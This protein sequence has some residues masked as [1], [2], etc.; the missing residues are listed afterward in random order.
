VLL[1]LT[2]AI[3]SADENAMHTDWMNVVKG[4]RDAASGTEVVSVEEDGA[5]GSRTV[6]LAIPKRA[7]NDPDTIEE[8]VVVG[9]APEKP[10]PTDLH[11]SYEWI[12]DYDNDN[13]G[14]VIRLSEN[15]NW[16]IRL[17]LNSAPGFT[18]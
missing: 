11:I 7:V 18:R 1:V 2:G 15:T 14:L 17:Y 4:S 9:Q 10:E 12:T 8:V 5:S 6:T 13:Y 16:P 3:A